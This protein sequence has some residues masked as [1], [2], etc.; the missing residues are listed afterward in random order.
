MRE[1][2]SVVYSRDVLPLVWS[3]EDLPLGYSL[4]VRERAMTAVS[5]WVVLKDFDSG[6][7]AA[8]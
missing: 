3:R 6:S 5:I 7:A 4:E 1:V 8:I 2:F